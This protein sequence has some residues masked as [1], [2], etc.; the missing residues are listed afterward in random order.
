MTTDVIAGVGVPCAWCD[1]TEVRCTDTA[2]GCD[3]LYC[4]ACGHEWTI[5]ITEPPDA[6]DQLMS[7]GSRGMPSA[8]SSAYESDDRY[9]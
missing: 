7:G 6:V 8:H 2:P 1:A 4:A 9:A 5:S 3:T